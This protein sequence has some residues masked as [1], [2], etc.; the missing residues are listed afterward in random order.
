MTVSAI[1]R[2]TETTLANKAPPLNETI[3]VVTSGVIP[4]PENITAVRNGDEVTISWNQ[5]EMTT[6]HDR[7]YLIIAF[8]CQNGAYLW[9]TFSYPDQFTTS[10]TVQDEAGCP[11]PSEGVLYTVEKHGFSKPAQI[12]WPAP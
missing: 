11:L 6:D 2:T 5:V 12:P 10:Y 1:S 4:S 7:G 8:V 9:W 3:L